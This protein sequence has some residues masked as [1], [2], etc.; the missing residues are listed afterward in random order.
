MKDI[1]FKEQKSIW[2]FLKRI[3]AYAF[4]YEKK[5]LFSLLVFAA[6]VGIIDSAYPYV[7]SEFINECLADKSNQS[8]NSLWVLFKNPC[9]LK[10]FWYLLISGIAISL[11]VMAFVYSAGKIGERVIYHMRAE[12]FEKLQNLPFSYFDNMKQLFNARALITDSGGMQKEAYWVNKKC[13]TI[14]T[15]TEWIETLHDGWNTL[16]FKD[17][18]N[19]G[20]TLETVSEN[21]NAD[22]YGKGNA[23]NEIIELIIA[24]I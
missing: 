20:V 17:L 21:W 23:S 18:S 8:G 11:S 9:M 16:M 4:K 13:V 22:L 2:P 15:E 5:L 19:L 6:I 1:E 14:R 7:F 24:D 12:M 10:Y 3:Y